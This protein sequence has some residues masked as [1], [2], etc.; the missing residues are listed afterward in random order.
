M[1]N[2]TPAGF[3]LGGIPIHMYIYGTIKIFLRAPQG[4]D[5]NAYI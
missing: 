4:L 2:S 3:A 1:L 5:K